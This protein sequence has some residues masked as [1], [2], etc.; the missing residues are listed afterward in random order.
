MSE[1]A[2]IAR[3]D[4][5]GG[6]TGGRQFSPAHQLRNFG[7]FLPSLGGRGHRRALSRG[8]KRKVTVASINVRFTPESGHW[9]SVSGR[10]LCAK[11]GHYAVQQ[12]AAYS[13]TSSAVESSDG[14]T[15]T[16]SI[17]AV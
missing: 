14:G 7:T 17:L 16:P 4:A 15:V 10:L 6:R 1:A 3:R 5:G 2:A 9:L 12:I 13:I 8:Y 11:S